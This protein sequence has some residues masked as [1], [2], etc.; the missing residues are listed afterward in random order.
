MKVKMEIFLIIFVL[1]SFLV[2]Y[3]YFISKKLDIMAGFGN[4][5]ANKRII[6]LILSFGFCL[7]VFIPFTILLLINLRKQKLTVLRFKPEQITYMKIGN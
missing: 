5:T 1:Y 3:T 4:Y 7:F 2:L 6:C